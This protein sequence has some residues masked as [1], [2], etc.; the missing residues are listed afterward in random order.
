MNDSWEYVNITF[1]ITIELKRRK[2]LQNNEIINS[3]KRQCTCSVSPLA[4]KKLG[5]QRVHMR[6]KFINCRIYMFRCPLRFK[7]DHSGPGTDPKKQEW[8]HLQGLSNGLLSIARI[9]QV[10]RGF[11]YPTFQCPLNET[12]RNL[13]D[14][15]SSKGKNKFKKLAKIL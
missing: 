12:P 8:V 13:C 14:N 1:A 3:H 2:Y 7:E 15:I 4:F 6:R 9:P 11:M 5:V 10:I